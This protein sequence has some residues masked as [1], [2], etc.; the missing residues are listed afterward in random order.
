MFFLTTAMSCS[1]YFFFNLFFFLFLFA[2]DR[3]WEGEKLAF[4]NQFIFE[5]V[6]QIVLW[7]LLLKA[8]V[9]H[10]VLSEQTGLALKTV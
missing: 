10:K 2:V 8:K 6:F 9:R 3:N 4:F 1:A 7:N 5:A